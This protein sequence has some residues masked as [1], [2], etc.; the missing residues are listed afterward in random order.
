MLN[1]TL[2]KSDIKTLLTEMR[3]EEDQDASLEKLATGL[4][5]IIDAYIKSGKATIPAAAIV[6]TGTATTQTGPAANLQL[7]IS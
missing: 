5:D 2:L 4:A 3:A 6:T 7:T 1:K